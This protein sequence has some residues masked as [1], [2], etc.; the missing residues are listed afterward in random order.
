MNGGTSRQWNILQCSKETSHVSSI[1]HVRNLNALKFKS[2]YDSGHVIFRKS[3][4]YG[5]SKISCCQEVA[6]MNRQS[7]EDL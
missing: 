6:G 1:K 3:Q 4:N 5:T 2:E 7:P